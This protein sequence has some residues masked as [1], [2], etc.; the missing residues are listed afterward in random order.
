MRRSCATTRGCMRRSLFVLA[1]L[2]IA[3]MAVT[4]SAVDAPAPGRDKAKAPG[5]AA[6]PAKPKAAAPKTASPAPPP[7]NLPPFGYENVVQRA[8]DLAAHPFAAPRVT[9]PKPLS[10]ASY[11]DHRKLRFRR[12]RALF[13]GVSRFE[14]QFFHL[15]FLFK[16][17]VKVNAI[18][19]GRAAPVVF[20]RA[21]FDY[22]DTGL[23]KT[24]TAPLD[25]AGFRVHYDLQD[26]AYKDELIVFLGASY[27]RF[28]GRGQ[29]YGLSARG[30]AVDT[31]E[32]RG[33]EF[34]FFREFWLATPD[35][36]A[37]SLTLYALLDSQRV[38]GA[39]QFVVHPGTDTRIDVTARLFFREDIAKLGIAPLTS[40]HL[41]GENRARMFDDHRPEVHDSDG[42]LIRSGSDA[43]LWRPLANGRD[44]RV[45]AFVERGPK[46]FGL[47]QRDRSFAHYQDLE[48]EYHRRASCWVEPVGDWGEG[49][50]E[51]VE[52]PSNEEIHDN[53]VLYWVPKERARAGKELALSYRL[54]S[55]LGSPPEHRLA[56]VAQTRI[57]AAVVPGTG[58]RPSA[59]RR[60]FVIEFEAGEIPLLGPKLPIQPEITSSAGV[61]ADP[62]V[63]RIEPGGRLRVTFRLDTQGATPAELMLRLLL[64]GKPITETWLYRYTP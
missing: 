12:E 48:S 20:D 24:I 33:E 3:A 25:F 52:I 63:E 62:H 44:L 53:I 39:Y 49:A 2:S 51:L 31:A 41:F 40:M 57:G 11:D 7:A 23:G 29:R 64:D 28:L 17:P 18:D 9:L 43:W 60:L 30:L 22:G 6:V 45:S 47:M 1:A 50:V 37:V 61:V 27:F 15:G 4:A 42:V 55:T 32:P 59:E 36:K 38:T 21:M 5:K 16:T 58:Q 56:R 26:P 46:G 19:Q 54:V 14:V 13:G 34:P 10:D 35:P 8:R